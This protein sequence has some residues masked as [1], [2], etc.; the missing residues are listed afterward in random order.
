MAKLLSKTIPS[1]SVGIT[2]YSESK[3][4]LTVVGLSTFTGDVNFNGTVSAGGTTGTNGQYLQSTGIGVTWA[5]AA[6]L[7]SDNNYTAT[8]GQTTINQTYT[9]GLI[10]VYVN[11]VR[12]TDSE[13]T[14]SNGTSIVFNEALF[15]GESIDV[16]SY[17]SS[18]SVSVGSESDTLDAVT[19]RGNETTNNIKVGV[20]T[21]T[22]DVYTDNIRRYTDN[23][24]NTKIALESGR[25]KIFAGNGVTPK[26]SVNGGV[27]INTNL[28]VTGIS[29]FAISHSTDNRPKSSSEKITVINGN[30]VNID[31]ASGGGNVAICTNPTGP[32][33]LN[34]TNI[35]TDSSFDNRSLTLSVFVSQG[36][37]AYACSAITLNGVSKNVKFPGSIVNTGSANAFDIFNFTC[38]NTVGSASSTTNYTV[39]GLVNGNF[40]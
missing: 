19:G 38:V 30:T 8:A 7:R 34:V 14:A 5:S 20:L 12:L 1:L 2:S 31:F 35:P 22:G 21:A 40:K 28:N 25:V 17:T 10:D 26:I 39:L 24:S 36:S 33:T 4:V 32:I 6:S 18:G 15:G 27:G 13:Y 9:A 16:I 29:T 11:G 37:V 23:S 3:Q